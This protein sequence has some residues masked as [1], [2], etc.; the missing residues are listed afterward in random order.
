M[1]DSLFHSFDLRAHNFKFVEIVSFVEFFE[2]YRMAYKKDLD[3]V[4]FIENL[5]CNSNPYMTFEIENHSID[6]EG[7][8]FHLKIN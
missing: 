6:N 5:A 3:K 2:L 1:P 4:A 8:V 7:S